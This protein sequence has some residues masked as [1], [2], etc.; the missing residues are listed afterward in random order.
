LLEVKKT[1]L[2]DVLLIRTNLYRDERGFFQESWNKKEIINIIGKGNSFVQDNHSMSKLNAIRGLHYQVKKPQGKLVRVIYGKIL[3][4]VVD[5]TEK[6]PT[7]GKYIKVILSS[8]NNEQI[9]IPKGFAHG[10]ISLNNMSHVLYKT[11]DYYDSTDQNCILWNDPF[12]DIDWEIND[13]KPIVSNKDN[14]GILFKD[15]EYF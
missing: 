11:T 2:K 12:L 5:I 7:F 14:N 13:I 4:I 8:Q 3:D 10:F 1:I 15:A 6:S 9:W